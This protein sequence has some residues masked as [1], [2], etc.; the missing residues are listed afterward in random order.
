MG[1][2]PMSEDEL[3][4]SLQ[5]AEWQVAHGP[6]AQQY[7]ADFVLKLLHEVKRLRAENAELRAKVN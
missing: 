2:E 5:M 4:R 3:D 1:D 6:I 7:A